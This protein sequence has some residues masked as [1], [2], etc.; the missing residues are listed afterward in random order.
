MFT[1][2]L[3]SHRTFGLNICSSVI[4][5]HLQVDSGETEGLQ[6]GDLAPLQLPLVEE[7]TSGLLV[8]V[9]YIFTDHSS[10]LSYISGLE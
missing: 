4:S 5:K 6:K 9:F 10:P 3:H 8:S 1:N 7:S 2:H